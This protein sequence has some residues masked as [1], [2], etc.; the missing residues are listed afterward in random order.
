[1]SRADLA[2]QVI[3]CFEKEFG[4]SPSNFSFAPGRINLIGEHVDYMG[5]KVLPAAVAQGVFVSWGTL[6]GADNLLIEVRCP[7]GT[8]KLTREEVVKITADAHFTGQ[9]FAGWQLFVVG[10]VVEA[11]RAVGVT[12]A[13]ESIRPMKCYFIGNVPLGSGMSSSAG[14]CVSFWNAISK[15]VKPSYILTAPLRVAVAKAARMIEVKF[16]KVNIGIM[17]QF[18]S[19]H[20]KE[21]FCI[22]L[23]CQTLGFKLHAVK[24]G[25][26]RLVL[27]NSMI[28]HKLGNQY[29]V[30]RNDMESAQRKLQGAA[31]AKNLPKFTLVE[32][33]RHPEKWHASLWDEVDLTPSERDRA[34]YVC[35]EVRRTEN[36]ISVATSVTDPDNELDKMRTLGTLLNETHYGLSKKL[37]IST[38]QIDFIH[39]AVLSHCFGARLMGGGFGGC[40]LCLFQ[41]DATASSVPVEVATLFEKKFG[42]PCQFYKVQLGNGASLGLTKATSNL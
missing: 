38:E 9:G 24:L 27:I 32:Y 6:N 35:E 21:G 20:G 7:Y 12:F 30:I 40:V 16:S 15:W 17:D 5:G 3:C 18:A 29:N 25:K 22:E 19:L 39:D 34:S 8:L 10:I 1:M 33:G 36:F 37:R 26:C 41:D 28:K 31:A 13:E 23:D 4:F 42:M 14:L 2:K 11:A